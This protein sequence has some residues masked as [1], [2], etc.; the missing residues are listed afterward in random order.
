MSAWKSIG[1]PLPSSRFTLK[2]ARA[3]LKSIG[4]PSAERE[5]EMRTRFDPFDIVLQGCGVPGS[6]ELRAL[7]CEVEG[8]GGV[9]AINEQGQSF[10]GS[11]QR[12]L[13]AKRDTQ[14]VPV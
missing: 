4:A 13:S 3:A 2:R 7:W 5:T 6:A 1:A 10:L 8:G 11:F 14:I 9:R 12:S